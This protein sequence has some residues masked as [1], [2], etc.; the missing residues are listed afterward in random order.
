MKRSI[1]LLLLLFC[2]AQLVTA[3]SMQIQA[4]QYRPA[5]SLYVEGKFM[6][7]K[8]PY[9]R[10]DTASY[11]ELP[12]AVKNL[13]TTSAGIVISFKTNSDLVAARW[14]VTKK[15]TGVNMTAIAYKGLDLYIR[16]AGK[17]QYAGAAGPTG[18]CSEAVLA[19]NLG[20]T[21][22]ECLLYL[23]LYDEALSLEVGVLPGALLEPLGSQFRN[24]VLIYGSSIVH[25]AS[26][27]RPGMAYP[28]RLS[29]M[30]GINFFN[31][32]LSGS[33]KMEKAAADLVASIPADAYILDCIPNPSPEQIRERSAYLISTLRTRQPGKPI[34]V[35]Q[36]II[37]EKGYLDK[38]AGARVTAQN[39]EISRQV[40]S[41]LRSGIKDLYFIKADGLLGADHEATVD[42]THPTDLG[43]DRMLSILRPRIMKILRKYP[44][45][46]QEK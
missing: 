19:R 17:W 35:M 29:R 8:K 27:S 30:T 22:K 21:E 28:A 11:P 40:D 10:I 31:M 7:T 41:L 9:Q 4:I 25:G 32:G 39:N 1:L 5:A 46:R 6:K 12:S 37:R 15:K 45:F 18:D 14:C 33:A 20:H 23:P 43:F 2:A 38:E 34:I 42:G 36:S 24:R 44:A 16:S 13:L 3:Q 26:A